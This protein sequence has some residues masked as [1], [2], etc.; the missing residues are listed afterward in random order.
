MPQY[1]YDHVHLVS[2]DPLKT[3]AFYERAFNARMV[4]SGQM[5]E[6]GSRVELNIEGT[7]LLIRTPRDAGSSSKDEPKKRSGLEHFGLRTN[8]IE[9]AVADLKAKGVKIVDEL[10]VI[11]GGT[12]IAFV[13]A[14]DNVLIEILQKP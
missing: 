8:D 7:R 4:S 10:R 9:A 2:T 14:P 13:M 12:K 1:T 5:P 3:A 11:A 6:G